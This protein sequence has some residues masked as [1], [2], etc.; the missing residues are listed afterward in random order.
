MNWQSD[1]TCLGI[2]TAEANQK[3]ITGITQQNLLV[4]VI[5]DII[6]KYFSFICTLT[7]VIKYAYRKIY[8]KT[9]KTATLQ[10]HNTSC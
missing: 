6:K 4:K 8:I 5:T 10:L 1:Q 9:Y 2:C 3:L 7:E